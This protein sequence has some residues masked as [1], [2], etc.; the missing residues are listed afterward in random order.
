MQTCFCTDQSTEEMTDLVLFR[1]QGGLETRPGP[2]RGS[3]P[4]T[5]FSTSQHNTI[6]NTAKGGRTVWL[7]DITHLT[8]RCQRLQQYQSF[9]LCLHKAQ[10][11][12]QM[13]PSFST[14]FIKK[15]FIYIKKAFFFFI[16][17]KN[18]QM[19]QLLQHQKSVF[20]MRQVKK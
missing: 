20:S 14:Q 6:M 17:M 10:R 9:T 12:R 1:G 15:S 18:Q 2:T 5:E 8:Q 13:P 19:S 11:L 16:S 4:A 7:H 3:C